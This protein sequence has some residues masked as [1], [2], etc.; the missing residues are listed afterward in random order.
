MGGWDAATVHQ[1]ARFIS[2]HPLEQ[3]QSLPGWQ[4]V[5]DPYCPS[6]DGARLGES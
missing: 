1:T 5:R 4:E 3:W 6:S 2:L